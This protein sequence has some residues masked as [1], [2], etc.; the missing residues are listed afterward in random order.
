VID[1]SPSTLGIF[2]CQF[3]TFLSD[4]HAQPPLAYGKIAEGASHSSY[5]REN[6]F[7]VIELLAG[8][9]IAHCP[10]LPLQIMAALKKQQADLTAKLEAA[11]LRATNAEMALAQVGQ[12]GKTSSEA[13]REQSKSKLED[14]TKV[15]LGPCSS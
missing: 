3:I 9:P 12:G 13:G 7:H 5:T 15:C 8:S 6:M 14:L 11:E 1:E 10:L 2:G 4:P